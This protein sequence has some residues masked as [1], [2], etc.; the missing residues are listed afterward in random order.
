M[1][2]G[3]KMFVNRVS[4]APFPALRNPPDRPKSTAHSQGLEDIVYPPRRLPARGRLARC[5]YGHRRRR[6]P[7]ARESLRTPEGVPR[8]E[9]FHPSNSTSRALT[10]ADGARTAPPASG[11]V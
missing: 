8:V 4:Q 1:G 10:S 9:T 7:P 11:G 2:V 3:R 5:L 6:G